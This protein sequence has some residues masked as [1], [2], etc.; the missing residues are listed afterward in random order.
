LTSLTAITLQ[1]NTFTG[2]VPA[3]IWPGLN[4]SVNILGLSNNSFNGSVPPDKGN[5]SYYQ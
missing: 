2:S 1:N 3:E 4:T 5:I